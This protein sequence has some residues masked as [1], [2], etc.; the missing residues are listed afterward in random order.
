MVGYLMQKARH[1]SLK[2]RA[3]QTVLDYLHGKPRQSVE[4]LP[5]VDMSHLTD[6]K[7][8]ALNRLLA[9]VHR[10]RSSRPKRKRLSATTAR[11]YVAP[12]RK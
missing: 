6:K 11:G 7:V 5:P 12:A 2:L 1:D 10:R 4:V 3:A 8:H 9:R